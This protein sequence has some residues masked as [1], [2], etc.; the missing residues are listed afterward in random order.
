VDALIIGAGFSGLYMLHQ[1][2]ATGRSAHAIETASDVGG[3][4]H[5]NGYPGARCDVEST[6]YCYSFSEEIARRWV[7]SER[8]P[9]RAELVAYA[10]FVARELELGPHLSLGVTARRAMFDEAA[11]EWQVETTAGRWV[12]RYL[13][14]ATGCLS[15]SQVPDLRGLSRFRGRTFHT[16]RWPSEPVD[17]SG[18][19]VAVIGTGS[20]GVQL[21]PELAKLAAEVVVFQRT[22][23]F[24]VPARNRPLDPAQQAARHAELREMRRAARISP[25]GAVYDFMD[26]GSAL[27]VSRSEAD[28]KLAA[29]WERGGPGFL[30]TF[31]DLT[32]DRS[33]NEIAASFVRRQIH[34]LVEDATTAERLTP[35]DHP[36]GAKRICVDTDYYATFNR[37]NVRLVDLRTEPIDEVTDHSVRAGGRDHEVDYIVFATGYDAVTGALDAIEIVG[38]S[39]QRLK[40]KWAPG[41]VAYLGLASAG[42]PNLFMVTGPGSPSILGN[43]MVSIEQHV[44]FVVG[45]LGWLGERQARTVEAS[46]E[47]EQIWTD[48]VREAAERTL[49]TET[50]SWYVGANVPGKPR[51]FLPYAGGLDRYRRMCELVAGSG[52][53]GFEVD[54]SDCDLPDG[55][56]DGTAPPGLIAEMIECSTQ[57]FP[58]AGPPGKVGG[59]G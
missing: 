35:D 49:F 23:N 53:P 51:V 4:W 1:L 11:A 28:G 36:I 56:A 19:R 33:A 58:V 22:P 25:S 12:A 31:R 20:S 3:T 32:S 47:A 38:R 14:T 6:F 2:L 59:V 24:S 27:A 54:R 7:W 40:D 30:R 10:R 17:F 48:H 15:A 43:V 41:P 52:F 18:R 57:R 34:R 9:S 50:A 21:V 8:Y 29:A 44:E 39:G 13:I 46:A 37:D 55:T 5:W 42:F 16:G 45:L 26:P